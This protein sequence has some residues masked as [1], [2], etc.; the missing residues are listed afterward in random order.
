MTVARRVPLLLV[1][2]VAMV[3]LGC[4]STAPKTAGEPGEPV[5]GGTLVMALSSDPGHLNPAITTMGVTHEAAEPMFNGLLA[6]DENLSPVPEL[7][8][9]WAVEQNGAVYRFTL[10]SGVRW[11]DGTPFTSA[12][13]KF[14]FE[15]LLL[16]FHGR[17]RPSIR[18]NLDSIDTPDDRTV[19]FRFKQ[20]YAPFLR[21]L[22]VTEAPILPRHLY[23]GTD[24]EKN[25]VNMRPVGTGPFRF[26]SFEQGEIN[27]VRNTEYFK[28]SLPLLD[29]VVMRVIPD[30]GTR[31][32][33]L[34]NGEVDWI[35]ERE[36][37]G[38]DSARL[39]AA[40]DIRTLAGPWTPG[41]ANC[42]MTVS[43]NLD[44]P[45]LQDVRVRRAMA[46]AL[47]RQRFFDSILF[48]QGAVA[49]APISSGIRW[50]HAGDLPVPRFDPSEAER[51]LDASGWK[52]QGG[53]HRVAESVPGVPVGTPLK[54][55][56]VLFPAFL[57][58][59]ELLR[60]QL[61]VVGIDVELRPLD[62]TA[63]PGPV[64]RDRNFD[65]NLIRYCHGTDPEIGVR[66]LFDSREIGPTPFTNAAGYR[67]TKVDALLES[68]SRS[69]DQE[70]R[71]RLYR[72]LQD[73]VVNDLPY[74]WIVETVGAWAHS[75]RC[76]G[77]R[78]HTGLFLE[79]ASCR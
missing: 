18:A 14:T 64:F 30:A 28:P 56:F 54:I 45:L 50:A 66:R 25:P 29:K 62:P 3:A 39:R 32:L 35:H 13:V 58:Y 15:E 37:F 16:R 42:V 74:L 47:N 38:P 22:D 49:T 36:G 59:G 6:L 27:L 26:V 52:R 67:N 61:G 1:V 8:A 41:G 75:D 72:E 20:P 78:V 11:H 57:Q 21:Q 33:A 44:R 17:A 68:A 70:Q 4:S 73:I 24:V 10:A 5:R 31:V 60:Q 48:G 23:A 19:V 53:R 63:F 51:L 77:F 55:D 65:T 79:S 76:T 7:A 12:D 34:E 69:L 46:H 9:S 43:F 2:L 40:P 71:A